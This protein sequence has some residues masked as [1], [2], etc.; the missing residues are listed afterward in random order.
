M[1]LLKTLMFSTILFTCTLNASA[2]N[3]NNLI[4][5][6]EEENGMMVGQ[7]VYKTNGNLLSN[8]MKYHYKY[9]DQ[10][11]MTESETLKW[12]SNLNKWEKDICIHYVY[13]G[14]R[15]T[16]LYYKWNK[17]KEQYVLVPEMTVTMTNANL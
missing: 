9:D 16:T 2:Y 14:K 3:E 10:N 7:T 12:N 17:K 5:N 11:R 1:K 6:S 15:I 4:Y 13:E 8:Y